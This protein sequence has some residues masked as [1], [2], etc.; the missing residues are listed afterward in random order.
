MD[1][2]PTQDEEYEMMYADE[3]ELLNDIGMLI[4]FDGKSLDMLL[5]YS[6]STFLLCNTCT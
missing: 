5:I 3:L 2:F 6:T 4:L 1:E